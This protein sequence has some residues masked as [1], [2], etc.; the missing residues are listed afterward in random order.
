MVVLSSNIPVVAE[1]TILLPATPAPLPPL[2]AG[3]V[4]YQAGAG[5]GYTAGPAT[6]LVGQVFPDGDTG[7]GAREYLVLQDGTGRAAR[8][9]IEF[10][11]TGGRAVHL[12]RSVPADARAVLAVNG[13]AG[14]PAGAHGA[15]VLTDGVPVFAEQRIAGTAAPPPGPRT[16]RP[17]P[18]P[19][20]AC[21]LL[22][23]RAA[24]PPGMTQWVSVRTAPNAG[25]L[26]SGLQQAAYG[27]GYVVVT[28]DRYPTATAA[29]RRY[30]QEAGTQRGGQ[31]GRVPALGQQRGLWVRVDAVSHYTVTT[32]LLRAGATVAAINVGAGGPAVGLAEGLARALGALTG[33]ACG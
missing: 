22:L 33:R 1:R 6:A 21:A 26:A 32:L 2:P 12:D 17:R 27:W 28:P 24:F 29:R 16:P 19:G 5:A 31:L 20:A 15:V 18:G 10:Y 7:A 8:V 3:V 9:G 11:T 30:A 25:A 14:L 13:V 23:P 4:A